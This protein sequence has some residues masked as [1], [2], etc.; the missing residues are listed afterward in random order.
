MWRTFDVRVGAVVSAV[1]GALA[2]GCQIEPPIDET[3]RCVPGRQAVC[4]CSSGATGYK[5]CTQQG[6]FGDCRCSNATRDGG[7][8][9]TGPGPV[10]SGKDDDTTVDTAPDSTDTDADGGVQLTGK[11]PCDSYVHP[12]DVIWVA[13]DPTGSDTGDGTKSDPW[14]IDKVNDDAQPGDDFVFQ[15]GT[16]RS[17]V[18]PTSGTEDDDT[19]YR[20]ASRHG[21]K[22]I[23][24]NGNAP[25]IKMDGLDRAGTVN[26]VRVEGFVIVSNGKGKWILVRDA[27]D[28]E[29]RD[30]WMQGTTNQ[31][32][33]LWLENAKHVKL[34]D[35]VA[36]EASASHVVR[37]KRGVVHA[38]VAG[39][40]FGLSGEAALRANG[41]QFLVFR[42]NVFHNPGGRPAYIGHQ[43][44]Q[45]VEHNLFTNGV[46]G[47]RASSASV[48]VSGIRTIFRFN[49]VFRMWGQSL[50]TRFES[51]K[52]DARHLR[53][54]H[55]VIDK[56]TDRGTGEA[57]GWEILNG[58]GTLRNVEVQNNIFSRQGGDAGGRLLNGD[59]WGR[60]GPVTFESN[61]F[62]R[63]QNGGDVTFR[64]DDTDYGVGEADNQ[65]GTAFQSNRQVK[66]RFVDSETFDHRIASGSPAEDAAVP[67][68][69]TT[70]SGSGTTL[71]V[72]DVYAFYYGFPVEQ[73][74]GDVISIGT[75]PNVET[76]RVTGRNTDD[77][78]LDIESEDGGPL[79]WDEG[80]PVQFAW[81]GNGPDIGRWERGSSGRK[82]VRIDQSDYV[83]APG[84][85]VVFRPE[86]SG[87]LQ[88][89]SFEWRLGERPDGGGPAE[90]TCG[91]SFRHAY[92][93]TG[94]YPV[95]L[96]VESTEGTVHRATAHVMVTSDGNDP[97]G[98]S[99]NE[100][101]MREYLCGSAVD[102][103][104]YSDGQGY[105]CD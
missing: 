8:D 63:N 86:I 13:P 53:A 20:P 25:A 57:E 6:G 64:I 81:D 62:W 37:L 55:N 43:Y 38:K 91:R 48:R 23:N 51:E 92:A 95:R 21:A 97:P 10:D 28:I 69:K 33:P 39:N 80:D 105:Y 61:I 88:I 45:L 9:E 18:V 46:D 32:D 30:L 50:R 11:S 42:G 89:D 16:Y 19:T 65:L 31:H 44:Q 104:K 85:P 68:A 26:H 75:P 36:R 29:L 72:D 52:R 76:A 3:S 84:E 41:S 2:A 58:P 12:S 47:P 4:T 1:L 78:T 59:G 79:S 27:S 103:L 49:R 100:G 34:L 71:P 82:S 101:R 90:R 96:R 98:T 35:S 54:Y 24:P 70:A 7:S 40:G 17:R 102:S 99:Y 15:N 73:G 93:D 87:D 67:L 83:V 66:P 56:S 94:D 14:N 77:G 60:D 74:R 22:I 5:L